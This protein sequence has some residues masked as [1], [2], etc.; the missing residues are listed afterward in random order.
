MSEGESAIATGLVT[1][2]GRGVRL[3]SRQPK[4]LVPVAGLPLLA[5]TLKAFQRAATIDQVVLVVAKE[6]LEAVDKEV[7]KSYGLNKVSRI[8]PGGATRQESVQ[9]GL[10][11]V[12]PRCRLVAIHDGA[13][14]LV[15]PELIDQ[16]V[17][18]ADQHGAAAAAVRPTDTIRR[19][20][21][22]VFQVTLD[23]EKLWLMQTPQ[24]FSYSLILEAHRRA[25]DQGLKGTDDV[26]LVEALGHP[27]H[28]VQGR[29]D[30]IKVTR[31]EDL[32]FAEAVL[33]QRR[34]Y[35]GGDR[36]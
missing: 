30:N 12:E 19:G 25:H 17:A 13:R 10:Q 2:A 5:H 35:E 15:T 1:A 24:V 14:P 6:I 22:Q 9:L 31:P 21:G 4:V 36:L 29:Y 16:T 32:R 18:L 23:R 20:E 34:E 11:S 3:G 28:V 33:A 7:V 26:A 27:V 8:V